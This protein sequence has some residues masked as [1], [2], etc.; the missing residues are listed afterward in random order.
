[1]VA[2]VRVTVKVPVVEPA[3][4]AVG[5]EATM[6]TTAAAPHGSVSRWKRT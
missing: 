2:P 5:S 1:M 3:S 4:V 6:V